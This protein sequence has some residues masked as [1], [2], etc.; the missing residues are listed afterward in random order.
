MTRKAAP[1]EH[2][3]ARLL[4]LASWASVGVAAALIAA[5][6]VAWI[7]TDSVAVLSTLLD[8][9]LDLFASLVIFVA[10]RHALTPADREHRFG[11]GKAEPLAAL[12]QAA[13]ITGSALILL[14]QAGSRA[15]NPIIVKA[16]EFGIAVTGIALFATTALIVFQRWVVRR[17]GSLAISA[18]SLHYTGDLLMNAAVIAALI[19]NGWFGWLYADP[20]FGAA[21]AIYIIYNAKGIAT[22]ALDML[23]DRELP[24]EDRRRIY[25]IAQAHP[26][27]HT[28]H[29]L[30]TRQS[31]QTRFIQLHLEMKP[32]IS[33]LEA[34][35]ISDDVE[36]QII[37]AFPDAEVIIHQDPEGID[38]EHPKYR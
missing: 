12:T 26:E 25:E 15:L 21:I 3:H 23:M 32:D 17:T 22:D 36:R 29:D 37:D 24:E 34:H 5:K 35:H 7:V 30:K 16:P 13:F 20:L 33:L 8:S 2:D 27:T 14:F 1:A 31:G 11:H 19:L 28:A 6:S 4:K 18:D 9:L 38:E 10:I